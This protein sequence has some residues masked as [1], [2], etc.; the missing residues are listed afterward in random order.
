MKKKLLSILFFVFTLQISLA[1]KRKAVIGI[2]YNTVSNPIE[3]THIF[4]IN[5]KIGSVSDKHGSFTIPI[6]D[7]DWIQVS[8]IQYQTKKIR[9]KKGN[10]LEGKLIIHLI[11]LTN[12][13]EEA[14][15]T[16]KLKGNLTLDLLKQKKDTIREKVKSLI[17][18][19]MNMSK[20]DIN[21]MKI[22]A[23]ERH[24]QK[25]RNAQYSTDPVAKF[26]GLPP[27]T[28]GIKDYA[29]IA[30][31]AR[32]ERIN[33]KESFPEKLKQLYGEKFFFV[34]LKIPKDR[35]YHFLSYC[36]IFGIESLF[37]KEKHLELIKVLTEKGKS[38]LL[39][40]K[41]NEK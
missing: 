30:K 32:R 25:P 29:L 4:N 31:R 23:K 5:S 26:A 22:T 12:V 24:L 11:P 16:K 1:Q 3:N 36:E 37:K 6:K 8:N 9:I 33:F 19:I 20:K 40:L 17:E 21:N 7:G 38:Y 13:L 10:I 15:I 27:S 34:K 41:E 2:I 14:V 28:I 39:L 18:I 35:Y